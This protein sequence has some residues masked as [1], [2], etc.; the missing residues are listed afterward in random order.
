MVFAFRLIPFRPPNVEPVMATLMPF[1]KRYTALESFLFAF[2]S[3]FLFD[4][5]TSGI[6]SWTWVTAFVYGFLGIASYYFFKNRSASRTNFVMFGIVGAILYDAATGL[7]IGPIFNGQPFM[8]ALIG[9]IPFTLNHILGNIIFGAILSP[10]V[11]RWIVTNQK[12]EFNFIRNKLAA[13]SI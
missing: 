8:I 10:L 3:I 4:I 6:G 12:L 1:S 11:Y 5:I 9:Q 13:K 7:T 2:F